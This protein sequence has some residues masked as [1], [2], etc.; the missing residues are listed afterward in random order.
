MT[1]Q[2]IAFVCEVLGKTEAA[3]NAAQPMASAC[4]F[5]I[6]SEVQNL[7]L[8]KMELEKSIG[9][10]ALDVRVARDGFSPSCW[11]A[12]TVCQSVGEKY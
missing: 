7:H 2:K 10:L 11:A 3:L 4:N 6:A 8:I 9:R 5:K 1:C 12:A